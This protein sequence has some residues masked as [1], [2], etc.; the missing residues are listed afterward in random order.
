MQCPILAISQIHINACPNTPCLVYLFPF[1][2]E[3]PVALEKEEE[4]F[5]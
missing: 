4:S 2:V 5:C 3:D 1:V